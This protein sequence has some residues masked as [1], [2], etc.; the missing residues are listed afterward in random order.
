[1]QVLH[2]KKGWDQGRWVGSSSEQHAHGGSC[3]KKRPWL[4]PGGP[5]LSLV[6]QNGL[7]KCFSNYYTS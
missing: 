3:A 1:M 2:E 6:A 5:I 4:V 7:R